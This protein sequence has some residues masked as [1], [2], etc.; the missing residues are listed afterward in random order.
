MTIHGVKWALK[1]VLRPLGLWEYHL[2]HS[3][4]FRTGFR[5][6]IRAKVRIRNLITSLELY[7]KMGSSTFTGG[8]NCGLIS[9]FF[10]LEVKFQ[11]QSRSR[12]AF[13]K[14][15]KGFQVWGYPKNFK[16]FQGYP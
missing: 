3:S 2:E 15:F 16:G 12:V 1:V 4:S 5:I 8:S 14:H 10:D 11:G 9:M 6:K 13:Y 7:Q